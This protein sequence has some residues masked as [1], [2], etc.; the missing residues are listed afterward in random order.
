VGRRRVSAAA[1]AALALCAIAATGT[2]AAAHPACFGAASRDPRQPCENARLGLLVTPTP[3]EALIIPNAPCA[4]VPGEIGICAFGVP[5]TEATRTVALL[6]DSHAEHWRAALEVVA[7]RL[8]W[9]IFSLTRPSCAFT[10]AIAAAADPK[11]PQCLEWNRSVLA[12][13]TLNPSVSAIVMSDHS[14]PVK[15]LPG[16]SPL[17]AAVAGITAAW[18]ALPRSVKHVIAIRDDPFIRESTLACVERAITLRENAGN[19]CAF[20]RHG[21]LHRDPDV[22]SAQRLRSPHVQVVDLTHFFCGSVRC[23]PVVGGALVYRDRFDHL[24]RTFST[25]LGPF[26]LRAINGLMASWR[27]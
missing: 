27:E 21:A 16:Q 9:S 2:G 11:R 19:A 5:T 1:L 4:P 22:V 18:A 20:P 3:S 15:A 7:Q 8:H 6:G 17:A 26:L 13:L 24:T 25:S 14:G 23:Y 12:W 10:L